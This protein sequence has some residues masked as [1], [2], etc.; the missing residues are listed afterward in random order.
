MNSFEKKYNSKT[1]NQ[2]LYKK[3]LYDKNIDLVICE[4]PAGT[5]KTTL[6]SEFSLDFLCNKK[7]KKIII[8]RPTKATEED[9]GFLPGDINKKM[10]PWIVPIFDIFKEYFLYSEIEK[11]IKEGFIEICPLGFIQGRT[12]K[13]TI[14]IADEMQNSSPSQMFMLLTRIGENSKIIINGDL[15]QTKT[16][17][18]LEDLINKVN[19][20]FP[21][22]LEKYNQNISLIKLYNSDIQ[23]HP[24]IKTIM[25]I[26]E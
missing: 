9:L 11:L 4:G 7:I 16:F 25:N 23:R 12:F 1:K 14:I 20:N 19:N 13:D 5:G 24:I 3:S 10:F 6:A 26:Y 17:N 8:I 15:K 21:T 22:E 18:G 2:D